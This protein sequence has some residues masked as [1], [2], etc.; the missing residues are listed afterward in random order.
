MPEF[1][2][3]DPIAVMKVGDRPREPSDD[4]RKAHAATASVRARHTSTPHCS[5]LAARSTTGSRVGENR[6]TWAMT[7]GIRSF[8][9][10]PPMTGTIAVCLVE[11]V[12][13]RRTT[14]HC[15]NPY[16]SMQH[17]RQVGYGAAASTATSTWQ[18]PGECKNS[19]VQRLPAY[20][21]RS[22]NPDSSAVAR[23]TN[24]KTFS[25]RPSKNPIAC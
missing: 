4:A 17:Q 19:G 14:R 16:H 7:G 13:R 22:M 9:K 1:A 10:R 23:L 18:V 3:L 20:I 5:Y 12:A 8:G 11:A 24:H 6:C 21:D 2:R 15:V 25:E